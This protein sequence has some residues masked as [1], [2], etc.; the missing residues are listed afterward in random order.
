MP[1]AEHTVVRRWA[2][3]DQQAADAFASRDDHLVAERRLDE[4]G[5]D[6]GAAVAAAS[7]DQVAGPF[8]RYRRTVR[9]LPDGAV[10][11]VVAYSLRIPWFGWLVALPI[12]WA[13]ARGPSQ[14]DTGPWWAP[15]DRLSERQAQTLGLLASASM[16][17]AFANTLFTQT[18][19]LAADDFGIGS[20][21]QGIGGAVVRLGIVVALPFALLADRIGRRRTLIVLAWCA[22]L[23]CALG[24]LAPGFWVLVGSQAVA[25]PIGIALATIAIVAAAEDMPRNSR[26]Y[27]LSILAMASG[28]GAGVA[29]GALRLADLGPGAWRWV[30]ALALVWLPVALVLYRRLHETRRFETV[31]RISPPMQRSRLALVI[32]VAVSA[33]L[34]IAPASFFQNRYLDTVR[35]YSAGGI[36]LFTLATGTPAS[37]GLVLGGRLADIVG[38]RRLIATCTPISTACLV[39]S[40]WLSGAA[41]WAAA[42]AG[43]ITAAMAYPAYAVYR[44]ELF[45]TG[46]RGWANGLVTASALLGGSV[47]IATIGWLLD[48]D[49]SFGTV[50]AVVGIGQL[51]GAWLAWRWYP[52][53]AHLEL[54]QLNPGDPRIDPDDS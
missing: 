27:A 14:R 53:T 30:Y 38:R 33:N 42:F 35:G 10:E 13:L 8:H 7:F 43:G 20:T 4:S 47:S 19:H 18:A 26:A 34:F 36:A 25:R 54:E 45:P 1:R 21:G 48:R 2:A 11:Q 46:N 24:A 29:V 41:M 3:G 12:R 52:E 31:H 37:L 39:S 15:P 22:P 23:L 6:D 51:V 5:S 40:F 16:T 32:A 49:V 44:T 50:I 17:A 9:R 28:L